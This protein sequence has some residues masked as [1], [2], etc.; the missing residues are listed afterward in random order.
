MKY[1]DQQTTNVKADNNKKDS[2]QLDKGK[3]KK[4]DGFC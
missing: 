2:V 1:P 4:K 3:T